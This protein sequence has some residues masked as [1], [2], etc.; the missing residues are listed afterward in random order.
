MRD[1]G[2]AGCTVLSS[3]ID[4]DL[5]AKY[6]LYYAT[7]S[8]SLVPG[9][10]LQ[11]GQIMRFVPLI[12]LLVVAGVVIASVAVIGQSP[13]V[14][15]SPDPAIPA[16][17]PTVWPA[18][19]AIP[20]V[21]PPTTSMPNALHPPLMLA[22]HFDG[23]PTAPFNPHAQLAP[24]TPAPFVPPQTSSESEKLKRDLRRTEKQLE[25]LEV[26][27]AKLRKQRAA[28]EQVT[29]DV[30]FLKVNLSKAA[31]VDLGLQ[32]E[33]QKRF[34]TKGVSGLIASRI[35]STGD[36]KVEGGGVQLGQLL[37]KLEESKALRTIAEPT[38]ATGSGSEAKLSIIREVPFQ[39]LTQTAEGAQ[40]GTTAFREVGTQLRIQ[41]KVLDSK[42][43]R[44]ELDADW[45]ELD[46]ELTNQ[47]GN[48]QP[49]I[50]TQ[51]IRS[52]LEIASG[53]TAVVGGSIMEIAQSATKEA[54]RTELV[55]LVTP[56]IGIDVASQTERAAT[57]AV[58]STAKR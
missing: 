55:I 34:L 21:P 23:P 18:T 38:I 28:T 6:R 15:S 44:L 53:A 56:R 36:A 52:T 47:M 49:V 27:L 46:Q 20:T 22:P 2:A 33:D 3:E 13:Q 5:Q 40:I 8:P 17:P 16:T 7:L 39:Q 43:I 9:Q 29:V 37:A 30:R 32:S 12:G 14:P 51:E 31:N 58:P 24:I 25:Y 41:P 48:G 10:P 42:Q 1:R 4:I 54:Q 57:E 26:E 11:A 45:S 35:A 19:P 50:H